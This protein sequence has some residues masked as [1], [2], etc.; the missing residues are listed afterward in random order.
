MIMRK[1]FSNICTLA[2]LLLVGAA[3]AACSNDDNAI[4]EQTANSTELRSYTLTVNASN[5]SNTTR[6]LELVDGTGSKSKLVAKWEEGDEVTVYK[7]TEVV[8]TLTASNVSVSDNV[9]SA[10]FSGTV[11]GNFAK[12]DKLTLVYHPYTG[13]NYFA[14]QDGT[15]NGTK[16]SAENYD[17]ADATITVNSF[18]GNVI[19]IN[20]EG[21]NFTTKT[22][23]LKLKLTDAGIASTPINATT[24]TLSATM[25]V[26]DTPITEELIDFK[27]S[28]AAYEAVD[29]GPGVLYFAVPNADIVA[30]KVAAK[31]SAAPYSLPVTTA[32]IKTLLPTATIT[33]TASDGTS[34]YTDSR[35][36]YLFAAG[37]YY[38][39]T[40]A[41]EESDMNK[42]P[43]TILAKAEGSITFTNKAT[44]KVTYRKNGAAGQDIAGSESSEIAVKAGDKVAF[45]GD[46]ATYYGG[47]FYE[48]SNF[49]CTGSCIVY[50][51]IMSLVS[52][53]GF[54]SNKTL[55][56]DYTFFKLFEGVSDKN[57]NKY[58][59]IEL[60]ID[61][62]KPL[63][64]PATKL[65]EFCYERMFDTCMGLTSAPAL[66]ATELASWCYSNMFACCTSLAS[67]PDLPAETLAESCYQN[68]F[69]LCTSLT[70]APVL[71]AKTLADGCYY[72][73]FL[74][75]S[76]LTSAPDLPA[77]TLAK[78]CYVWMFDGCTSL[79]SVSCAATTILDG[80]TTG[81]LN[82]V[83]AT[84]TFK[85][86]K[87]KTVEE[88][89]WTRDE[90]GIPAGW[91]VEDLP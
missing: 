11:T 74:Y 21:V 7:G 30:E 91:T 36:G 57:N 32:L 15:L 28:A 88:I 19:T 46:N 80:S 69:F 58:I 26:G 34:T 14:G 73:M 42:V 84:G 60:N 83:P 12:D 39:A 59:N 1:F 67:A 61:P 4:D 20:E 53:T 13:L 2:I 70:S 41:L 89:G 76:G 54:A 56:G 22:A 43:L 48:Y 18:E 3:I 85:K 63:V 44:G 8:G 62:T 10:T 24:L 86:A 81:W 40:L 79:S 77:E 75:C 49:S 90:D 45:Y 9:S 72:C 17:C 65:T 71:P 33:F 52:S 25:M 66:P 23:V 50:G 64:L 16:K 68:M 47:D 55:T 35:T 31:Y 87:G 5:A 6:A 37:K 27:P 38:S 78:S 29:N 82:D 51:N